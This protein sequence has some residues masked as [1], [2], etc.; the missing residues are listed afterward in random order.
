ML[1]IRKRL[2]GQ[3]KAKGMPMPEAQAVA[4]SSLQ[5][6]GDLRKGSTEPTKK[7]AVRTA[8]G[9][10]GR[11]RDRAATASGRTPEEFTYNPRTN[12]ATLKGK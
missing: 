11:A 3:L 10:A 7:G 4:T 5:K 9:A 2:V 8:M 12:R 1:P 6:A